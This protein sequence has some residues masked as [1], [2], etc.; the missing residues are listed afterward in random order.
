MDAA[1]DAIGGIAS[2]AIES[3][4]L[5]VTVTSGS[6]EDLK[7]MVLDDLADAD[8]VDLDEDPNTDTY[9][10][11]TTW[12][13]ANLTGL[14]KPDGNRESP[15][16][17]TSAL[18]ASTASGDL[19]LT[20]TPQ[21]VLIPL[22]LALF[23]S[24]IT[25]SSND[26]ITLII[27]GPKNSDL[28]LASLA[29]TGGYAVPSLVVT[30]GGAADPNADPVD[31]DNDG[32]ADAWEA[33]YF[34]GQEATID[35]SADSD[36]EGVLDFFE[37]LYGSDPSDAMDS[38]F[39]LRVASVGGSTVFNWEVQDGFVLGSDYLV[40][41]STDLG[42]PAGWQSLPPEDYTLTP[43]TSNGMTS[44]SLEVTADYGDHVFIRLVQP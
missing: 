22:D 11:E 34:P 36:G 17:L 37:Y 26:E 33:T 20:G 28:Y 23:Q 14:N 40:E 2:G 9:L 27:T 5:R 21:E 29:N 6:A 13:A 8:A 44:L 38:G 19:G 30:A 43:S 18:L 7:I 4:A 15:N 42:N 32:L 41:V 16:D 1:N 35:G 31:Q 10:S 39:R 12:N 24:A 3:V 25:G